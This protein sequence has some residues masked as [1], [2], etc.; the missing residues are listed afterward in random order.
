MTIFQLLALMFGVK[1]DEGEVKERFDV[2]CL[3]IR[4]GANVNARNKRGATPLQC[5]SND[6]LR[7]AV[8]QFV[9]RQ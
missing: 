4:N 7:N 3:L 6:G 9:Q 1:L 2:A 5:G 8:R